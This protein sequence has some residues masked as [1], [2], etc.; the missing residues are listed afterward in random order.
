MSSDIT[1]SW[2]V[3][4]TLTGAWIETI[5][6]RVSSDFYF[7]APSRVRGLKQKIRQHAIHEFGVAP[8]RVRGLKHFWYQN[9][10][11]TI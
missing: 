4:R 11:G 7:V 1:I 2:S 3:C 5:V 9:D 10:V 8:S 6:Y